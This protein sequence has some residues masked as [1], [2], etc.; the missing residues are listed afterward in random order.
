MNIPRNWLGFQAQ[1][2]PSQ[3]SSIAIPT[4]TD[5]RFRVGAILAFIAWLI[6]PF[7]LWHSI[8]H[9]KPNARTRFLGRIRA[10]P[11]VF[12]ATIPLTLVLIGYAEAQ[13]WLWMINVGSDAVNEGYLYGFGYGPP[14]LILYFNIMASLHYPNEDLELIRQ[15]LIRGQAID[16]ELGINRRARKPWWWTKVANEI[17]MDNDA[18]LR[19]LARGV[20]GRQP[21]DNWS[22]R[23]HELRTLAQRH[24]DEERGTSP[25]RGTEY[26][27]ANATLSPFRDEFD[28]V[29]TPVDEQSGHSGDASARG[30]LRRENSAVSFGSQTTLASTNQARPQQVRSMLDV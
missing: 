26:G 14:V 27:I 17:G 13:G 24:L 2:D 15:R 30:P 23:N 6:I 28:G 20:P 29:R 21:A 16:A 1:A 7:S 4:A 19:A 9:Y 8:K 25:T 5:P 10:I 18:K 22:G 3:I 12:L 11:P